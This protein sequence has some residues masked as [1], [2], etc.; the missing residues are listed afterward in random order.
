MAAVLLAPF[1]GQQDRACSSGQA[2][3]V[4][5]FRADINGG[6]Y[7]QIS[8]RGFVQKVVEGGGEDGRWKRGWEIEE[9]RGSKYPL[10]VH[11]IREERR[12]DFRP[13]HGLY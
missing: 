13:Y 6:E 10:W 11:Q 9:E 8:P 1:L 12:G 4:G 5:D 7:G 2:R 3:A